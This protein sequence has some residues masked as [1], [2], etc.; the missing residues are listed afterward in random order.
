MYK[1]EYILNIKLITEY[2]LDILCKDIFIVGA[3][4][5][6]CSFIML[7]LGL[8][9]GL[10]VCCITLLFMAFCPIIMIKSLQD[11]SKRLNNGKIE[12]TVVDFN[13]N[14]IMNE[15]R[16]HLEFEYSQIKKIK[17]T[18]NFI[19]LMISNHSAILVFK[20]GFI[21]GNKDEFLKFINEKICF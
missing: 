2:V 4:L 9:I 13:E 10:I 14:I 18:K 11:N 15:G 19:V 21:K 5:S 6:I 12:K 8:Y 3:M 17:Q 1:N 7:L 16:V 20:N